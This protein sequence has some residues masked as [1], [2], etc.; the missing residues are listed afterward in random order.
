MS[1]IK[2]QKIVAEINEGNDLKVEEL[3]QQDNY[4]DNLASEIDA[5]N[6]I[7]DVQREDASIRGFMRCSHDKL[8]DKFLVAKSQD[9]GFM[10]SDRM[11][12]LDKNNVSMQIN[13]ASLCCEL[14]PSQ[15]SLFITILKQ[16]KQSAVNRHD[17][18]NPLAHAKTPESENDIRNYYLH[19]NNSIVQNI[20]KP[21]CKL[22]GTMV[23]TAA[24][25]P[26]KFTLLCGSDIVML[27]S[28]NLQEDMNGKKKT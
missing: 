22:N 20:P 27:R 17:V 15:R 11:N 23:N 6:F 28:E 14:R 19:G 8:V 24:E 18:F 3:H 12:V 1:Q 9:K 2:N 16:V 4:F 7:E 10:Q 5:L 13:I 26:I 21:K 25:E